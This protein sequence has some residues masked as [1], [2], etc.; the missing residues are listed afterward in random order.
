MLTKI[1]EI[2]QCRNGFIGK[3]TE[4]SNVFM[5]M[6]MYACIFVPTVIESGGHRW[7]SMQCEY[8]SIPRIYSHA[9]NMWLFY[10]RF[11]RK[12]PVNPVYFTVFLA[13]KKSNILML[14]PANSLYHLYFLYLMQM[15]NC[16][17]CWF[18]Y[19]VSFVIEYFS[20]L[21]RSGFCINLE[22]DAL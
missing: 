13:F 18:L 8:F 21:I 12:K 22:I 1:V 10:I 16:C 2:E 7:T 4:T 3:T 14:V 9:L 5:Y 15:R 11:I 19:F 20:F 6:Y 17:C